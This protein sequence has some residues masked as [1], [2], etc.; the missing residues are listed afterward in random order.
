MLSINKWFI[1]FK[2]WFKTKYASAKS[3]LCNVGV[4]TLRIESQRTF[5]I[6][7]NQFRSF[8]PRLGRAKHQTHNFQPRNC[9]FTK[10]GPS[11]LFY[12]KVYSC[13][14][15]PSSCSRALV[16]CEFIKESSC[17]HHDE[18]AEQNEPQTMIAGE[19]LNF[20]LQLWL[21]FCWE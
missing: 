20:F 16:S 11:F 2:S 4:H 1:S 5:K 21:W 12:C 8:H 9:P 18:R 6:V 13:R 15:W 19:Q 3:S 7:S 10:L 14:G 17:Q